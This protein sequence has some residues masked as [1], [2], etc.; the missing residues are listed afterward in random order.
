MRSENELD[1]Q[2]KSGVTKESIVGRVRQYMPI[3]HNTFFVI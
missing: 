3:N 1:E 2:L